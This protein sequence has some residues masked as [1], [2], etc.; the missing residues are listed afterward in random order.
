MNEHP[1]PRRLVPELPLPPYTFVPGR[2]PHPHSDPR[3]HSFG[4]PVP[5]VEPLDPANW[6]ACLTYLHGI[7]LFHAGYYWE[8]HEAWER[9]WLACGRH[10][11][12]AD[13][14]KALI[15]LAAA[16]V[17]AYEGRSVGVTTHARRAAELFRSVAERQQQP[18]AL[19]MGLDLLALAQGAH[20]LT[21]FAVPGDDGSRSLL[22]HFPRLL[23]TISEQPVQSE[24]QAGQ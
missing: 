10:G 9:L 18:R 19:C 20:R 7:D 15:Q 1:P 21:Q 16:G 4:K 11:W 22:P 24:A 13:L 2:T 3:G 14:L 5:P 6:Q 12:L 8:A 17:K 23:S